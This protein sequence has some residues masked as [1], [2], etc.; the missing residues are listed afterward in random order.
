MG[1]RR[2]IVAHMTSSKNE[3]K[4]IE[5]FVVMSLF[6]AIVVIIEEYMFPI[7][8]SHFLISIPLA[9]IIIFGLF[10]IYFNISFADTI[11][12]VLS[13][14]ALICF[15]YYLWENQDWLTL[16]GVVVVM[17]ILVFHRSISR[18]FIR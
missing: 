17:L 7:R 14:L 9:I 1:K 13:I 18:I 3:L 15:L 5:L 12:T 8:D 2:K 11:M 6:V 16:V 10:Y 4:F